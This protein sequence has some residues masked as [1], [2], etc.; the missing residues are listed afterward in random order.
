MINGFLRWLNKKTTTQEKDEIVMYKTRLEM[1]RK[2]ISSS[3]FDKNKTDMEIKRI[4]RQIVIVNNSSVVPISKVNIID[5]KKQIEALNKTVKITTCG[6]SRAQVGRIANDLREN[7]GLGIYVRKVPA[8]R[9]TCADG[10]IR[11]HRNLQ[12]MNFEIL[13]TEGNSRED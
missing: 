4:G 10:P 2:R 11:Y 12:L 7:S 1:P 8:G 3:D 6:L 5:L 9:L 13:V